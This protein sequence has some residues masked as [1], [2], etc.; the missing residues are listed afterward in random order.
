MYVVL[1][2]PGVG[3]TR[4][5]SKAI[6]ILADTGQLCILTSDLTPVRNQHVSMLRALL[7]DELFNCIRVEGRRGL[8]ELSKSRTMPA[9]LWERM[10]PHVL[11]Y[12]RTTDELWDRMTKAYA[13]RVAIRQNGKI[14]QVPLATKLIN[15]FGGF[16][17]ELEEAHIA[18][19]CRRCDLEALV[20]SNHLI[21][22]QSTNIIV[23]TAEAIGKQQ[24]IKDL[25]SAHGREA[26]KLLAWDEI[27]RS[28]QITYNMLLL[29]LQRL[30]HE[31]TQIALIGDPCQVDVRLDMPTSIAE[32]LHN[33]GVAK[34]MMS[35]LLD[36]V[37]HSKP[38]STSL[39]SRIDF[40]N[41][42]QSGMRCPKT[43]GRIL[44]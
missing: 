7:N 2:G 21:I 30:I 6:E 16:S 20:K 24:C 34:S 43:L 19:A 8:D 26:L 15:E 40:V 10:K 4:N 5:L 14:R 41:R 12:E 25:I 31:G 39:V 11:A 28:L 1:G 27:T 36:S 32:R 9:L 38:S 18:H 44:H 3:M 23:G 22:L 13:A 33:R 17:L 29:K 42:Y 37:M 35:W